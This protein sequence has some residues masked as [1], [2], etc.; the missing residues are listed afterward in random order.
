MK[1]D[2]HIISILQVASILLFCALSTT[3]QSYFFR[4]YQV[5]NGLSNNTVYS[6]IQDKNGFL[7]FGTKDGLN[8]FDG[9]HFKLFNINDDGSTLAPDFISCLLID[10]KNVL[11]A[12]SQ[13]GL[14]TFDTQKE[15][16]VRFIDSFP[17]INSIQTD[18]NGQL[19]FISRRTLCRYN[20]DT[21]TLRIF[22]PAKYFEATSLCQSEEGDIWAGTPNGFL[23]RF[24]DSAETF[25]SFNIFSH[26]PPAS[27][28]R[29][30]K[31]YP[32]GKGSLFVGTSNQ[33]LKRFDITASDYTDV[34]TLNPD[35][36]TVFIRDIKQY[37]DNEFWFATESGIF[38]LNTLTQK[39]INLKKKFLD[40]YSLSDN[41]VYTLC[42][43]MEGGIWAGTFFGGINYYSKQYAVFRKYFPDNSKKRYQR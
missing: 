6:S 10:K 21:K 24:N 31:I 38:I 33:G 9:Y 28:N 19:W 41:A 25:K 17:E 39:F 20:F 14:F 2:K 23:Q 35:K 34:L 4:H 8:R 32:A 15:R 12:G 36:T 37:S 42:K 1:I 16:L 18:R 26:S 13:K 29:I 43:D 5:E 22:R 27:S 11:W 30:Q 40:P 7:W 3:A